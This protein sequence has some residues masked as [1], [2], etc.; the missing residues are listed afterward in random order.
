[1]GTFI[2]NSQEKTHSNKSTTAKAQ[3]QIH[4]DQ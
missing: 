1:M 2:K 3:L 4:L